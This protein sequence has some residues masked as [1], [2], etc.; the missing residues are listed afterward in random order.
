VASTFAF[1]SG[2]ST[3]TAMAITANGLTT[4]SGL[5]L[6]T[7]GTYTATQA[8]GTGIFAINSTATGVTGNIMRVDSASTGN[9]G[10]ASTNGGVYFGFTGNHTGRA[11]TIYDASQLG[12]AF[13]VQA[14]SFT[15]TPL[16]SV[17]NINTV[18][19]TAGNGMTI[20]YTGTTSMTTGSLLNLYSSA[21]AMTTGSII[22]AS[23][24]GTTNTTY[25]GN[26]INFDYSGVNKSTTNLVSTTL[27]NATYFG[28]NGTTWTRTTTTAAVANA[29]AGAYLEA[30]AA[31]LTV[32]AGKT[33]RV[34]YTV[35]SYTDGSVTPSVGGV[36]GQPRFATGTY[37]DVITASTTATLKFNASTAADF[38]ISN[39]SMAVIELND[40][41]ILAVSANS[42]NYG[43]LVDISSTNTGYYGSALQV[44][45]ASTADTKYGLVNFSFNGARTTNTSS[46]LLIV[47]K[48]TGS[49]GTEVNGV[50]YATCT[51]Q[52]LSGSAIAVDATSLTTGT[53]VAI[54]G[55]ALTSGSLLTV[56]KDSGSATTS[57]STLLNV[58]ASDGYTNFTGAFINVYAGDSA[59][60]ATNTGV[61]L[62]LDN[63]VGTSNALSMLQISNG[64]TGVSLRINDDGTTTDTTP[65]LVDNAGNVGIGTA[66]PAT[67]LHVNG[68]IRY[69]NRPAAGTITA[70][71]YDVNGDLKNSSSSLRY[72]HD[73]ADY[74]KGLDTVMQLRPVTFKFNGEDR[75]NGGFIAEEID[76][77]GLSEFMLYDDQNRPDGVLYANMTSLLAKGIQELNTKV[78]T[79]QNGLSTSVLQIVADAGAITI[80]GTLTI[81]GITIFNGEVQFNSDTT[82]TATIPAGQTSVAV[83]FSNPMSKVP[84]VTATTQGVID[85]SVGVAGKSVNGFTIQLRNAQASD[86]DI[87]WQALVSQ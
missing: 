57:A 10:S 31:N 3:G 50:N 69:T 87:D 18:A 24:A 73:I 64:G 43:Q 23:A 45:S 61:M 28:V 46:G 60:S 16:D 67:P 22:T 74:T 52:Y 83:T 2:A 4:G 78:D 30:L 19:Q 71:G 86:I 17:V 38:T 79:M 25:N 32:T 80:N 36:S 49:G 81:N 75:Q 9:F 82:G 20:A 56:R 48:G 42:L 6:S 8:A 66:S 11:V 27:N 29:S 55:N 39:T 70:I 1:N 14:P 15:G 65:V 76:A 51:C 13:S 7:S 68:T 34:T 85:G 72:K 40:P 54:T 41:N 63:A 62:N 58:V 35:S 59:G 21:T 84:R 53:A 77:L 26:M 44:T 5:T 37:T 12:N 33:Y 47:D